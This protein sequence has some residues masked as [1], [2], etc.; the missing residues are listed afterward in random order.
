MYPYS[1]NVAPAAKNHLEAQLSF[2]NGIS[3]SLFHSVQKVSDLHVQ[4]AQSLLEEATIATHNLITVERPEDAFRVAAAAS[5]PAA[6]QLRVYQQQLSRV[7]ADAQVELA[8]VAEQHVSETSRTAKALAEEVARTASEETEKNL[9]KQHETMQRIAEPFQ[10]FQNGNGHSRDQR[11]AQGREG[12]SLQ[13]GGQGSAQGGA[14][15][16]SEGTQASASH[17]AGSQSKTSSRKE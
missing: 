2:F 3:K 15:S 8:N 4:L 14:Q 17:A 7:A 11:G 6:E 12:Q 16:A 9:R 5:Q 10:G 13:S 1:R